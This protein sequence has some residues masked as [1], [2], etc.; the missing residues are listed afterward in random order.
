M[1]N[2]PNFKGWIWTSLI[3]IIVISAV[4][5]A[6]VGA[7]PGPAG[8]P[9]PYRLVEGSSFD[10]CVPCLRPL[11]LRPLDGGFQLVETEREMWYQVFEV[12]DFH[13]VTADGD[14]AGRLHGT[15]K[16]G[17]DFVHD[18][19]MT[20]EGQINGKKIAF[21]GQGFPK[22][23]IDW[24]DIKLDQV[25]PDG[26]MGMYA[27]YV[28][29][30]RWPGVLQFST[31][32][33]FTSGN[34]LIGKVSDGD[35]L[36]TAGRV[37]RRNQDLT[38]RLGIMPMVPDLGLDAVMQAAANAVVDPA[39]DGS[40]VEIVPCEKWFSLE[41]DVFSETLGKLHEGDLLGERGRIIRR[42]TDLI[43]PF[44]PMPPTPDAGLDAV[45]V[46]AAGVI[47]FSTEQSFFSEIL[48]KTIQHS[49]LLSEK[50]EVY[51]TIG[52][53]M[54]NFS[55]VDP[56]PLEFGLDAVIVRPTT[57]RAMNPEIWFS[58]EEG[59]TDKN[60]GAVSDGDLLST[61]GRIV[62]KNL[63]LLRQFK[64]LEKLGNF[65]LDAAEFVAPRPLGDLD[66][67]C[68]VQL[69]DFA[70][71]A[72]DWDRKDCGECGG[73]DFAPNGIVDL[74]DLLIFAEHWLMGVNRPDLVYKVGECG[75]GPIHP[76]DKFSV[77]VVGRYAYFDDVFVAN[78]CA[79][80]IQLEMAAS[81]NDITLTEIEIPGA[82]CDCICGYPIH[83]I[84]GPFEPGVYKLNL[85]RRYEY[86]SEFV[87]SVTF[88]IGPVIQYS[89]GPCGG[90]SSQPPADPRFSVSVQG[91]YI[92]FKDDIWAN[93]CDDKIELSMAV[94]GNQIT[95]TET[96]FVTA[97]CFCM[98]VYP[99]TA[100]LGPFEP[101]VY[102][103][104]VYQAD[105]GGKRLIG[106]VTVAIG[107]DI[108]YAV[109]SCDKGSSSQP[110]TDPRFSVSV[111]GRFI[112]LK[113]DLW[114]NC[115][116]DKIELS[117]EV[118]N[119][120]ITIIETETAEHPCRC[121]CVWPTTARL[122]PFEPGTYILAVMQV[123]YTGQK[124]L[125]GTVKV[126]IE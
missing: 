80:D 125:I 11:V 48:G 55:P 9:E 44:G 2:K 61:T 86:G 105:P 32:V 12:R 121:M 60:L 123:D 73:A 52:E 19:H 20:L 36:N 75:G 38:R 59:F 96:E 53:L 3:S 4:V 42:Y 49:D 102:S 107:P 104:S 114:G 67:D 27:L 56:I 98:C 120:E 77:K 90:P 31:E 14:Y 13:F 51:R 103:L 112:H 63:H 82:P 28:V 116:D 100:R 57:N 119:G 35:L 78:C 33:N 94:S 64:P 10:D 115:C 84:L 66:D 92:H 6:A 70:E 29:A 1:E 74:K 88:V 76:S 109:G 87:G 41:E 34:K 23:E 21:K 99:T 65:G 8:Y 47:L 50:G 122:G 7:G 97:P 24:I 79:K 68:D 118:A 106:T 22:N 117:M 83:A 40:N 46:N 5:S 72:K 111:Q 85:V 30:T 81:G 17:G 16:I 69:D 54:E 26:E 18:H 110:P 108:Q 124:E 95:I 39:G 93:C 43:G 126:S 25:V 15:Y 58:T 89:V 101:G 37:V 71:F 45:C 62:M 91:R 113:D